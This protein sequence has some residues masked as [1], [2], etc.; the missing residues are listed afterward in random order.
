MTNKQSVQ[1]APAAGSKPRTLAKSLVREPRKV[2]RTIPKLVFL[3]E[4]EIDKIETLDE[5]T[6]IDFIKDLPNKKKQLVMKQYDK[7]CTIRLWKT[8]AR[9]KY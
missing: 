1:T 7:E 6:I 8:I 3:T 2:K 5:G 4:A 9:E